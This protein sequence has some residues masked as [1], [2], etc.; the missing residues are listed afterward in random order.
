MVAGIFFSGAHHHLPEW[1]TKSPLVEGMKQVDSGALRVAWANYQ[2]GAWY[3]TSTSFTLCLSLLIS[4]PSKQQ[5]VQS[6]SWSLDVKF[7]S[8]FKQML[9]LLSLFSFDFLS[10]ECLF[11]VKQMHPP[12]YAVGPSF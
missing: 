3:S 6:V 9:S 12:A 10:L 8:P 1:V 11:E 4:N 7:P 2:V 5:I